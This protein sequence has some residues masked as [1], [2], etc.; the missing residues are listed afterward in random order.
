[1]SDH[2]YTQAE[3]KD[4]L[5]GHEPSCPD[6]TLTMKDMNAHLINIVYQLCEEI[7]NA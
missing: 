1:M 3:I 6:W 7:E 2:H 5:S 4:V